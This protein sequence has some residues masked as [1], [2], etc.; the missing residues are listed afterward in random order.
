MTSGADSR[1]TEEQRLHLRGETKLTQITTLQERKGQPVTWSNLYIHDSHQ[2]QYVYLYTTNTDNTGTQHVFHCFFS[3]FFL[4]PNLRV[5]EEP[6]MG[7]VFM[8][9]GQEGEGCCP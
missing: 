6:I 3:S 7:F 1:A 5:E 9:S 4:K 2:L 8:P